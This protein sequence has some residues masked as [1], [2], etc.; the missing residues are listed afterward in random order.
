[1]IKPTKKVPPLVLANPPSLCDVI[2]GSIAVKYCNDFDKLI[3]AEM[4]QLIV[5][6]TNMKLE[7]IKIA[8]IAD[9]VLYE[10]PTPPKFMPCLELFIFWV[11]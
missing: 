11:Y 9:I 8:C 5:A 2:N 3:D 4:I 10:K 7:L 1:M 6:K